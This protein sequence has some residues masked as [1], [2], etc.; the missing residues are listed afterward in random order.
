MMRLFGS[1]SR[2]SFS[3]NVK[4]VVHNFDRNG[5]SLTMDA[6]LGQSLLEACWEK[7]LDC[8]E[9]ACDHAMAC[10]TCQVLVDES[11]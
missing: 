6:K 9:G 11:W 5:G 2:R 7:K 8:L 10:S 1:S 3:S 4:V